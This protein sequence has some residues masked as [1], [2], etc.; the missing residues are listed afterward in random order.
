MKTLLNTFNSLNLSGKIKFIVLFPTFCVAE[1]LANLVDLSLNAVNAVRYLFKNCRRQVFIFLIIF[2]VVCSPITLFLH[3]D[4][5]V[6][7]F[8]GCTNFQAHR[9]VYRNCHE[10]ANNFIVAEDGNVRGRV[11]A[12]RKNIDTLMA[13]IAQYD[14][15]D[16][17]LLITWLAEFKKG[18]YSNAVYFHNYCWE[19]LDGEVGYAVAIRR[20]YR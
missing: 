7:E 10:M 14:F 19:E 16:E 11:R 8:N 3:I 13:V 6:P 18:D 5:T 9:F 12:D 4:R 17:D 2:L 20:R 1:L 15:K